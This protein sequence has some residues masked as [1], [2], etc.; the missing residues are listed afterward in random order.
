[1]EVSYGVNIKDPKMRQYVADKIEKVLLL[2]GAKMEEIMSEESRQRDD[3][4]GGKDGAVDTGTLHNSIRVL[5][6]DETM[7]IVGT[8]LAY[9]KKLARGEKD[10]GARL[11][12]IEIWTRR[13]KLPPNMKKGYRNKSKAQKR[14]AYNVWKKVS[15]TGPIPNPF[16]ERAAIRFPGAFRGIVAEVA[17]D[18]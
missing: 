16:D 15:T 11:E 14:F 8:K 10:P 1:M 13:K 6:R 18:D 12:A 2:S 7:V 9:S 3:G 17:R 5:Y 4:K